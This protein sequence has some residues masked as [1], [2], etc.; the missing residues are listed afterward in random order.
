MGFLLGSPFSSPYYLGS[1][2]SA[3]AAAGLVHVGLG[4]YGFILD[5]K[6]EP[7]LVH[8]SV[9]LLKQQQDSRDLPGEQSINPE[10][11]WLRSGESWHRGAGQ[12]LFDRKESDPFRFDESQGV[13]IW[14]KWHL[15]L[16]NRTDQKRSSANTNLKL[17]VAGSFLY[18]TD[19]TALV[20]TADVSVDTPVFTTITG[21]PGTAPTHIASDGFNVVTA[22]GA[23]GVYKTT[24]GAATT[25]SHVT[26]TVGV[27]AFVK[28]RFMAAAGRIVY[29][30]SSIVVGAGAALPA[31]LFTHPNTDFTWVGFAE[32]NAAIYMAGVSGDKSLIYRAG[33][34][35]DGTALDAPVIAGQLPHGEVVTSIYGY[36]G[37]FIMI[38]SNKGWRFAV[39][40][41]SGDLTIGSLIETDAAVNCFEGQGQF[42]WFG[43][44]SFAPLTTGLGRFNIGELVDPELLIPA[45][46]SDIMVDGTT[47]DVLDVVTFQDL[48]VFTVSGSGIHA[49]HQTELVASGYLDTGEIS[50]GMIDPK[51]ALFV[52]AQHE[53]EQGQHEISI[54]SDGGPFGSLGVH[55]HGDFPRAVGQI[56]GRFFELRHTLY[57]DGDDETLGLDL[58]SWLLLMQPK[59]SSVTTHIIASVVIADRVESRKEGLVIHYAPYEV[60]NYIATLARRKDVTVWQQGTMA[61]QVIVEDYELT[62]N[63]LL[64]GA[65]GMTGYNGTCTIKMK[66]VE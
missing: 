43:W 51:I 49:R 50:W 61:Y 38:G 6:A 48:Q 17:A 14:D 45:Y 66:V 60:L 18:A 42:V 24:R 41:D 47:N 52:D 15:R 36:L 58:R 29:D 12:D 55:S 19:G 11:F 13:D 34:Q 35:E 2:S 64:Q 27:V 9:P 63:R 21:T 4:S 26:G 30:I 10:G 20:R 8:R 39:S 22:H 5:W 7:A 1:G 32:G 23:S 53:G 54:S 31:P 57:R 33:I 37:R 44:S 40:S 56:E 16:L 62:Y 25:A 59:V 28:N 65:E 3:D 46:A